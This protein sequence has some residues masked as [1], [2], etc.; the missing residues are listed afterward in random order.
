MKLLRKN[1]K[2]TWLDKT[3]NTI[4][5]TITFFLL[6]P[7]SFELPVSGMKKNDYNQKSYW[8]YPWGTSGTHKGVDIFG[9]KGTDVVSS[10]R[11]FTFATGSGGK[12]GN[13]VIILG[14]K[15]R[16]H[17]FA[18][19]NSI[20][21]KVG[22]WNAIGDK[23]GTLGAT[24]NAA[25]KPPHL[26]YAIVTWLPHFWRIDTEPQGY[27]KMFFLNPIDYLNECYENN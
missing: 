9:K 6:L 11:G 4:I 27:R 13:Y 17:Y 14:P 20:N 15:L 8:H 24:G 10:V 16:F 21:T 3:T 18:H 25:G 23:I 19:L 2:R 26:H 7:Q 12:A 5:L 1:K 22:N